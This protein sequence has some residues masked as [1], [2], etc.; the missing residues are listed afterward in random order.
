MKKIYNLILGSLL[1]FAACKPVDF[2][3]LNN[4]PTKVST[5]P[6]K[7]LLTN[8][9]Q[10]LPGTVFGPAT[11]S[12]LSFAAYAQHI[13]EGPYPGASLYN[14][15]NYSW[16]P[17]YTGPLYN[18]QTIINYNNEGSSLADPQINGSKDNQ[19]AVARILKAYYFWWLTD[20]YG[21]IPYSEALQGDKNFSPKY[22]LQK[23][24]YY[25][26]FKELKEAEAQIKVSEAGVIGD[27]L[28]NGNMAMWKKMAN[29]MRMFLALRLI[30]NDFAKGQAE[31]TDALNSGT[32]ASN[33]DNIVYRYVGGDPNN[34][35]PW[36][37]NYS[38]DNRNDYAISLT[39]TDF[40][41]AKSDPRERVYGE[42][43]PNGTVKGV[44]YGRVAPVNL[45]GAYSRIGDAF[46]SAG[47]PATIF[48]Y[49]QVQFVLAE[50]AKVNYITGGDAAAKTYYENG[51]KASFEQHGVFNATGYASYIAQPS[52]AYDPAEGYRQIIEQKWAHQYLN[53]FESWTDWRRTGFPALTPA[54]DGQE[55]AIP[56]RHG[57]PTNESAINGDAY[58]EAVAR[59]GTDDLNTR[60]WWD[61]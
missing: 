39:L 43:L 30:K 38:V 47:S 59:Q 32:L 35:N 8:S 56:R 12:T 13:S 61:K 37:Q 28:L 20:R 34:H 53:G 11:G 60:I 9:L 14:V 33:A 7:A 1:L 22:D 5:V 45:P 42:I 19:I 10:T 55:T 15:R 49:G 4:D 23:D 26:L 3:D 46:R 50:A 27:I 52:V 24:V 29:T 16:D 54:P 2:A 25:D 6:T 31:F 57:Y 17:T 58:D 36:Y 48:S 51:I 40:L 21:D 18:L 41:Q 44:P